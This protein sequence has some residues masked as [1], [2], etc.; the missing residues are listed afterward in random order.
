MVGVLLYGMDCVWKWVGAMNGLQETRF[1]GE[2]WEG[3]YWR[4]GV[5]GTQ[6]VETWVTAGGVGPGSFMRA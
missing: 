1:V 3:W 5:G 2:G 6:R 4:D